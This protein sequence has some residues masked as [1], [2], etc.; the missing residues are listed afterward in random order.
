MQNRL[1]GEINC[2]G[3][4]V[5]KTIKIDTCQTKPQLATYTEIKITLSMFPTNW[6]HV[7]VLFVRSTLQNDF[8]NKY[9][10]KY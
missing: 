6:L 1:E 3:F 5:N 7:I 4:R 9:N 2:L 8:H 10:Y